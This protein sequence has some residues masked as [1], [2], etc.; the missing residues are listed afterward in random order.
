MGACASSD[1]NASKSKLIDK[2]LS[3]SKRKQRA[4]VKILLLG[5]HLDFY[6]IHLLLW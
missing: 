2:E 3:N 4:Q 5:T 1:K 6:C